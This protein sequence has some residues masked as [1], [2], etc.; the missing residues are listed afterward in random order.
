MVSEHARV[1]RWQDDLLPHIVDRLARET[2]GAIYGLWPVAPDSYEAGFRTVTYAQLANAVNGLAWWLVEQLGPGKDHEVLT[3]VGPNDVRL[4]ALVLAAIK[5]GYVILLT[6]PRNSAAAHRGLFDVLKCRT[7]VTTDPMPPSV[8]PIIEAVKPRQLV[9]PSVEELL[10][11]PFPHFLLDKTFDQ[12]RW[13]PL[14]IIH[15]SGSTGLPKPMIWTHE[16]GTRHHK[17]TS[18]DPPNGMTSIDQITR[19]KRVI[20]TLPPFH[21]AGLGQY[22]FYAIPFGNTVIA[23]AATGIVT[24]QG[25]V[26]ALKQTPADIAVLVPSVVA[27]LAQNPDLLEYCA[28]QLELILYIGGDLP[29]AIGDRVAEKIR[30]RCQWGAS[31]VGIPQQLLPAEL[32]L[33][34]WHYIRFHPCTGAVFD[35]VADGTYELVIRRDEALADTQP[36]FS[37]RGQ[38]KLEEYRTKDLFERHPTVSDAWRWRARADD[39]IVFLNGEKTNPVTM[40]QHIVAQN[41][42]LSGVLVIGAQRF[43]AALLIEPVSQEAP[44]TTAGQAALIERIWPSV[45][46]ANKAAPAHARIEKTM[47]LVTAAD[48]PL[49]RAGKGTIQRSASLAQYV[50]DIDKLYDDIDVVPDDEGVDGSLKEDSFDAVKARIWENIS[51]IMDWPDIDDSTSFFD[52][53]MDSLQALRLTRA[54]RRALHCPHIA[55][56]TVYQNPTIAQLT[57]ALLEQN[58]GPDERDM[59]EP[60][61]ATY[62]GLIHQIPAPK[63]LAPNTDKDANVILTGSTGALGTYILAALL[64]RPGIGHIFCLNRGQN[65]GRSVQTNRFAGAGLATENLSERVT[66]IQ[67]DLAHPSLGLDKST[68]ESLRSRI[69]LIIHNAW[70]VNFNLSLVAF[71]PQLAGLVNLFALSA[72]AAP[73]TMRFFFIS[74]VGAVSARP[75]DAGPA[76]EA[77]LEDFDAPIANGYSRSKFLSELLCDAAA[78][79]L[80]VPVTIARVGQVA[81]AVRGPGVWNRSEWFPSLVVSSLGFGCLP[82][83][84]GPQFSEVDWVPTDLLADVVVDLANPRALEGAGGCGTAGA[85]VFNLRNP[86]TA[87]WD[88]LVPAIMAVVHDRLGRN[89]E[90]VSSSVWLRRL[91]EAAADGESND[92]MSTATSNPAIKLVSF[93]SNDLWADKGVGSKPMSVERALGASSTL[94][95]ISSV[96]VDWMRKWV[97]EWISVQTQ[98][99]RV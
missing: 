97:N 45:E 55:L 19:G 2:P 81:G 33:S 79:H 51:A 42:E 21:G 86:N 77:V 36:A 29:Q 47:I 41:P 4:T 25:L 14:F 65:G 70:P 35:E 6:S 28:G 92:L 88:K 89:I 63:S 20:A 56:S 66:F 38:D 12:A 83:S 18:R 48:R 46:E 16:T 8:A 71:R 54:L 74:S 44:L 31:E 75:A 53:G 1:A 5:A 7:L 17:F 62:R 59:M 49:I 80:R 69:G 27:E 64:N 37:M 95:D 96:G 40:E 26:D 68:Y 78:R 3:Y 94:R 57:S 52:R 84:L 13:D 99:E 90:V 61:L 76:P 91:Q 11:K 50:A 39:I 87:S 24:A 15:T 82:D 30:L 98:D 72:A 34:D 10:E 43:Q 60:L 23:P 85:T 9:V 58:E 32:G 93:Y 22:I 73:R 67:A